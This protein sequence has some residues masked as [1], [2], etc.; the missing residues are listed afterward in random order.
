M[1]LFGDDH[2]LTK[3]Y[4]RFYLRFTSS[5]AELH[6][7]QQ[8]LVT[9]RD[10]LLFPSKILKRNAIDLSYWFEMQGNTPAA[11]APPKFDQV[12]DDIKQEFAQW[13]PTMSLGFLK[14]LKLEGLGVAK[15]GKPSE[16]PSGHPGEKPGTTPEDTTN[17]DA[18][19]SNPHFLE[20]VFGEYRKLNKVRTRQI[21]RK[22]A[23][24]ELPALP[25][26]KVDQQPMCL[27]WHTKGQCNVRCPRAADH[28]A[29]TSGE[30]RELA[31]WCATHYPK[32]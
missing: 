14:E 21:R 3:A 23:E 30:A 25:L 17:T 16:T 1:V 22:I 18:A 28:V 26:S 15:P 13:E 2:R 27:A 24:K 7:H 6:R 9:A 4:E 11:R 5:E 12:F 8:G 10:Q 19:A 31:Q 32:E 29:Y 20:G